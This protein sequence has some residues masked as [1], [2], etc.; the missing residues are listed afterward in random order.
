MRRPPPG[1]SRTAPAQSRAHLRRPHHAAS[2]YCAKC[3]TR[4]GGVG[5]S[6]G[7]VRQRDGPD[8]RR[9]ARRRDQALGELVLDVIGRD[10][11]VAARGPVLLLGNLPVTLAHA[12]CRLPRQPEQCVRKPES[13]PCRP[14]PR[15]TP[16]PAR[17]HH[18]ANAARQCL[19]RL[20]DS[21]DKLGVL[22][23]LRKHRLGSTGWPSLGSRRLPALIRIRPSE[24]QVP[25]AVSIRSRRPL[26]G[27]KQVR[28]HT[29]CGGFPA[30]LLLLAPQ[31]RCATYAV[32]SAD[33]HT[34]ADRKPRGAT[35]ATAG[36]RYRHFP[37]SVITHV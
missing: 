29:G 8:G 15:P 22:P 19:F 32:T 13:L 25:L 24:H 10:D 36:V 37:G 2:S 9:G 28:A 31:R 17:N 18:C 12:H 3:R 14:A 16:L 26:L 33:H 6:H 20:I 21:G 4:I 1:N 35:R 30:H 7:Y 5:R 27:R 11:S 34:T 23:A